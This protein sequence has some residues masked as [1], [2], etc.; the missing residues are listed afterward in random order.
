MACTV[1][2]CQPFVH[3]TSD[4]PYSRL[5]KM[6]GF[7][8]RGV[9]AAS[10]S[11]FLEMGHRKSLHKHGSQERRIDGRP[12]SLDAIPHWVIGSARRWRTAKRSCDLAAK[13]GQ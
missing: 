2:G 1:R 11:R 7:W 3:S 8:T 13:R 6:T 4:I 10:V 12:T 9:A 5:L